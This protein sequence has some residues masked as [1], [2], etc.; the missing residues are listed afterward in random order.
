MPD[1]FIGIAGNLLLDLAQA[2]AEIISGDIWL[3]GGIHAIAQQI[4]Q[5]LADAIRDRIDPDLR[6][7]GLGDTAW[8][9]GTGAGLAIHRPETA[10]GEG[11]AAENQSRRNRQAPTPHG[12]YWLLD[13]R[14]HQALTRC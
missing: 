12:I 9:I 4:V 3:A 6:Q 1:I 10:S 8:R 2:D 5:F 13:F 7:L 14:L 11:D